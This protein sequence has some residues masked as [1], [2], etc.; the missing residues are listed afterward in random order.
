MDNFVIDWESLLSPSLG[1]K[2]DD[3]KKMSEINKNSVGTGQPVPYSSEQIVEVSG[4]EP[5]MGEVPPSEN[6][7]DDDFEE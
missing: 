2:L 6:V 5:D 7:E 3:S 1:E 4:L